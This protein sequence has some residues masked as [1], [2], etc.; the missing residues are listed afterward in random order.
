LLDRIQ[1]HSVCPSLL[2]RELLVGALSEPAAEVEVRH[3]KLMPRAHAGSHSVPNP[4][5][6]CLGKTHAANDEVLQHRKVDRSVVCDVERNE[7]PNSIG[8]RIVPRM[9]G[10]RHVHVTK[11]K[12]V[13]ETI[14][15]RARL[16]CS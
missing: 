7:K 5:V 13:A 3:E 4:T 9:K 15:K 1:F 10:D 12:R 8:T 16:L 11:H 2:S 6:G 14:E